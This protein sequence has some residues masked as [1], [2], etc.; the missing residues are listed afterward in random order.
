MSLIQVYVDPEYT[1]TLGPGPSEG[2]WGRLLILG[3]FNSTGSER[4]TIKKRAYTPQIKGSKLQFSHIYLIL[5]II[6]YKM[7][8]ILYENIFFKF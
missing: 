7:I 1:W 8:H 2:G 3:G 5:C 4:G 6:L